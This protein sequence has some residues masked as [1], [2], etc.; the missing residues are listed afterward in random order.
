MLPGLYNS[1]S[2]G[3]LNFKDDGIIEV[4]RSNGK[5]GAVGEWK[6]GKALTLNL[7]KL[8]DLDGE[9]EYNEI[10]KYE[11]QNPY[12]DGVYFAPMCAK[13]GSTLEGTE[14]KIGAIN[15]Y[16]QSRDGGP[17]L[18]LELEMSLKF[19]GTNLTITYKKY[20][21][22]NDT[23]T[24]TYDAV[25]SKETTQVIPYTKTD[26]VITLETE[27][28]MDFIFAGQR[29]GDIKTIDYMILDGTLLLYSYKK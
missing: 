28:Y 15:R 17:F 26:S 2:N 22:Y 1:A 14:W 3:S 8:F 21:E 29:L 13:G 10:V 19:D 16:D 25:E 20:K 11:Y 12:I 27:P 24:L 23:G 7:T 4:I 5:L 9:N 18:A 6:G